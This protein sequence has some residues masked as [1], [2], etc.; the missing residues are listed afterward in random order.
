M[1]KVTGPL[2]SLSA[3]GSID[4]ALTF[5]K[6]KSQTS[7]HVYTVPKDPKSAYQI[8]HRCEFYY[9]KNK[10]IELRNAGNL[11][12]LICSIKE[13]PFACY[14]RHFIYKDVR[15]WYKFNEGSGNII[16]DS[17]PY[18][19]NAG[20]HNTTWVT[21]VIQK[22]LLFN[23]STSYVENG[24]NPSLRLDSTLTLECWLKLEASGTVISKNAINQSAYNY[25]LHTD[26]FIIY[27]TTATP[28][29]LNITGDL[30]GNTWKHLVA[31]YDGANMNIYIDGVLSDTSII[32]SV[33][34]A[35]TGGTQPNL[36][37]GRRWHDANWT[38]YFQG[39]LD[40]IRIYNRALPIGEIKSHYKYEKPKS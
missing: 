6:W 17:S 14:I 24:D 13:T 38:S 36:Q 12:Q 10:W 3:Q 20:T 39:T 22:A 28:H 2:F 30:S 7:C 26:I 4:C 34:L 32:G 27:D 19:N 23:G 25:V 31:T 37:I 8:F 11:P 1:A 15:A 33:T 35:T 16:K 18:N 9:L 21:G 40:E 29:Q 5:Q